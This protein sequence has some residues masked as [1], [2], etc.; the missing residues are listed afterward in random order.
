MLKNN[1]HEKRRYSWTI[2]TIPSH[3]NSIMSAVLRMNR[4]GN[5]PF[6]FSKF[7]FLMK[8][9]IKLLLKNVQGIEFDFDFFILYGNISGSNLDLSNAY[10]LDYAPIYFGNNVVVG[11]DVK[12]ITSWHSLDNF[13]E[14]RAEPIHIGDNVWLTMNIIV[15]PGVT[16]GKNS[17]IGAGS[18]VTHSIPENVLAAG[19]PAKV[20]KNIIRN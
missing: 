10:L 18:V 20:I 6:P 15:L 1:L 14:V 3:Q 16:I 9:K 4:W 2:S 17:V 7:G 5:L 13:N 19:N 11:R 12:I 8:K